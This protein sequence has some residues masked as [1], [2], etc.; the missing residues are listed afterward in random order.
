MITIDTTDEPKNAK[1]T[2]IFA[3][4]VNVLLY[5]FSAFCTY[6]LNLLTK[7]ICVLM[8]LLPKEYRKQEISWFCSSFKQ[9]LIFSFFT[10]L[11]AL[12]KLSPLSLGS[13]KAFFKIIGAG[14][15]L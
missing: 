2:Y 10:K 6:P 1:A 15:I 7:L 13:V 5:S 3:F 14:V 12:I 9:D 11:S 8:S 4:F